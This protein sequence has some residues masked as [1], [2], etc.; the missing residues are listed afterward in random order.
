MPANRIPDE[1]DPEDYSSWVTWPA[2]M[3]HTLTPNEILVFG[4]YCGPDPRS[5]VAFSVYNNR[6][7]DFPAELNV[8]RRTPAGVKCADGTV[9]VT[10]SAVGQSQESCE[11]YIPGSA[12]WK[13]VAGMKANRCFH[14]A[15]FTHL[16][17]PLAIGGQNTS[18]HVLRSLER[19]NAEIDE[20]GMLGC[21]T[22]PRRCFGAAVSN[23]AAYV[24]GG[25]GSRNVALASTEA[26]D[27]RVGPCAMAR[28]PLP[29]QRSGHTLTALS[30]VGL[31]AT[32]GMQKSRAES[33]T[34]LHDVRAI[35]GARW[36]PC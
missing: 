19:Y 3:T 12:S 13:L 25:L 7:T 1:F 36:R 17:G 30:P 15:V 29:R 8:F 22:D 16:N 20:W 26:F 24:C 28:A 2:F 32:G 35:G 10:G 14:A 4:G 31:M 23:G 18:F 9:L 33:T 11:L 21:M 34:F 5:C 6:W 27:S